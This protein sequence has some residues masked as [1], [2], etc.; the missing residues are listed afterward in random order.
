M[1]LTAQN[2]MNRRPIT[3]RPD[4]TCEEVQELLL[5]N[6]I[7]GAPVVDAE[8]RLVGVISMSD[9]LSTGLNLVYSP[10]FL[11]SDVLDR[12]LENEGFHLE[13]VSEGFVADFMTRQ[14]ITVTPETPV[15]TLAGIMY[16]N[17]IHRVVVV[18]ARDGS[19]RGI[20]STFD[21]L[22]VMMEAQPKAQEALSQA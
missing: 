14:V 6:R 4:M 20:V 5:A 1:T 15:E 9:I 11:E 17:R 10:G 18:D 16:K 8:G 12:A 2:V 3:A 19:L 22:K 7:S 21:L 13:T